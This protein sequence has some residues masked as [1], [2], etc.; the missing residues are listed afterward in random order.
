[1]P[2]LYGRLKKQIPDYN[3]YKGEIQIPQLMELP[4]V[5]QNRKEAGFASAM[6]IRMLY[7]C[8]VDADF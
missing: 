6:F 4:F 1:M 5:I 7:S 2:T 3:A 8:L